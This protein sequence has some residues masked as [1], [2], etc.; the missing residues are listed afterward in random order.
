M[1]DEVFLAISYLFLSFLLLL[2]FIKNTRFHAFGRFSVSVGLPEVSGVTNSILELF[3]IDMFHI[4]NLIYYTMHLCI[5]KITVYD[6]QNKSH[7]TFLECLTNF[8]YLLYFYV[9]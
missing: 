9:M 8:H 6:K 7:I 4:G 5:Y 2:S 3:Q 1:R